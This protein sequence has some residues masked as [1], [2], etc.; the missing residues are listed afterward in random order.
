MGWFL[1]RHRLI[2]LNEDLK[3]IWDY[4]YEVEIKDGYLLI[5]HIPY[6][7]SEI[8]IKYGTIVSTLSVSGDKTNIPDTHVVYF[9][10]EY[11]CNKNGTP[12]RQIQHSSSNQN[13]SREI[14]INHS[15]SNKP[16]SG[17][18]DYFEKMNQYIDIISGPAKSL[19]QSVTGRTY[20]IIEPESDESVFN[21]L[22]TNSTRAEIYSLS[23]KFEDQKVAIIGL[24]GTGSYV[25]DLIA[26][27]PLKEIHLY[28]GDIFVQH[29]AFRAPGAPEIGKLRDRSKKTE[30]LKEIY[31]NMHRKI[32]SHGE[33]INDSNL[34]EL[35]QMDFIFLCIDNS[36]PKKSIIEYIYKSGIQ[37]VDVGMGV[38]KVNEQI[39]GI[40]RVTSCTENKSDH[41]NRRISFSDGQKDEYSKNIQI[42][43]L[44]ALNA[45]LAVIKWKK[46]CGFY[47]DLEREN[48]STYS[49]NVNQLL[50]DDNEL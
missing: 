46:I 36:K 44:N 50:N 9:I 42:A 34:T 24:G 12:I 40:L 23:S 35:E 32:I 37:F 30:Y 47:Q 31:S 10:G 38:D 17:Y 28:D 49:I 14:I 4:G 21:Y 27:T 22:D 1:M 45:T 3:K 8:K 6:L 43:D 18:K 13:L 41:L 33:Y 29:N 15:F 26:K 7:N 16:S 20:K 19:D 11:P 39:I 25:L 2:N 5:H 48:F